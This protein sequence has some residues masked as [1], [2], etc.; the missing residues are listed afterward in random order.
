MSQQLV[1]D[2][3]RQNFNPEDLG[4]KSTADLNH[5]KG[6]IGQERAM[7][8]LKFGL[9]IKGPGYNVFVAGPPGIGKMTSIQTFLEEL[10]SGEEPPCDWCYVNNF[11]DNYV[12]RAI[13]MQAG[14]GNEFREDMK[15]LIEKIQQEL[16]KIFESDQ[17]NARRK[18]ILEE[19]KA[20]QE[21]LT[22]EIRRKA[23]EEGFNLQSTPMGLM[24]V[25]MKDGEQM[26]EQEFQSMS[27]EEKKKYQQKQQQIQDEMKSVMKKI[28]SLE[29]EAR[30]RTSDL[31][32]Q[33]TL[34]VV[35]GLIEDLTDKYEDYKEVVQYLEEVKKDISENTDVFKNQN[36]QGQ[37][38][39]AGLIPANMQQQMHEEATLK[40]YRVNV[41]IDNSHLD[42]APVIMEFNP[43][44]NN[45]IGRIEKEMQMGALSTDFTMIKAGSLAK[46]NGGYIVI[47]IEDILK[48]FASYEGLKRAL[49]A[50]EIQIE[51]LTE[52]MGFMTTKSLR[53]EPIPLNL[54]VVLVGEP[55]Y[56][57]MLF[58][59]DPDFPELFKVKADFD[60]RMDIGDKNIRDFLGFVA[61]YC[62]KE[63]LK[64]LDNTATARLLEHGSRM[65]GD[66]K[67]ISTKFG[68]LGDIIREA[69]YWAGENGN[70]LIRAEDIEKALDEKIFRSNL[71]Q[72][73]I[74]EM[75]ERE[76]ILIDTEGEKTGQVNGLSVL[77]L[78]DYM[79]GKPSRITATV[80]PGRDGIMD[81]ER[82]VKLGGPVHSKGV[83]ILSGYLTRKYADNTPLSL[84]ARLVFEQSYQGIEGDSASAAEL[85]TILSAL[86][87]LPLKQ[88]IAVTGS[89][90]QNGEIQAIGG[91][92][93]KIEGFFEVCKAKGITGEQ[94]VIIPAS[95]QENLMLRRE[96][97]DAVD[98]GKFNIWT[99]STI[100][101]GLEILTGAEAGE[102]Q[103]DGTFPE[104]S[105]NARISRRLGTFEQSLPILQATNG[106]GK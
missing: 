12:P 56:Y 2:D 28:R 27:E 47:S 9:H 73:R 60:T 69:N 34:N 101:E 92:N 96:V 49:K 104:N 18:D 51:E 33:I 17:Y 6:I 79:F 54:K 40:K 84:S 87:N 83:M 32:K 43:T 19:L 70:D 7:H 82:E 88:G 80:A 16:P 97:I 74:Q 95:N 64:H 31:D 89:V 5:L 66:Q 8:A 67:K 23:E 59:Y 94:G 25:P 46:A 20:E 41:V 105:V 78:G 45:L 65:A 30:E 77:Q 58:Q 10:A 3:L 22:Q 29:R 52:R 63:N 14:K 42:G 61:T 57:Y 35:G 71:I 103:E 81:I 106:S 26:S 100:D 48:N 76:T 50:D 36:D 39:T 93:Q 55:I 13:S 102:R 62:R 1:P 91:V 11:Q 4:I 98:A 72:K 86:S 85:F 53:P 15:N 38:Q 21:E 44:Y 99:I 37:Q 24:L 68:L 75:I 90:N